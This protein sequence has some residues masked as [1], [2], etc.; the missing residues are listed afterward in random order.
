[1]SPPL[2][3]I[4]W[5]TWQTQ[6]HL[7][8]RA[9]EKDTKHALMLPQQNIVQLFQELNSHIFSCFGK[10]RPMRRQK[11]TNLKHFIHYRPFTFRSEL[12]ISEILSRPQLLKGRMK[13]KISAFVETACL[14]TKDG[15]HV[16]PSNVEPTVP[17]NIF[18]MRSVETFWPLVFQKRAARRTL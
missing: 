14:E 12:N 11:V 2:I 13:T 9:F 3:L 8:R 1:M 15:K 5:M 16:S 6:T 4:G 17:Y 10:N 18:K 7:N